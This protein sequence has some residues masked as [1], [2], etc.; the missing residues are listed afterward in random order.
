MNAIAA[1]PWN[2]KESGL[3]APTTSLAGTKWTGTKWTVENPEKRALGEWIEFGR[4][5]RSA[6]DE[7]ILSLIGSIETYLEDKPHDETFPR[8]HYDY[9]VY[10]RGYAKTILKA[11]RTELRKRNLKRPG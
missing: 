4:K 6:S 5:L 8:T 10:V 2:E 9:R 7:E 1:G 11:A 3:L